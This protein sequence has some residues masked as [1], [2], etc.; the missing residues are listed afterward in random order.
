MI[1]GVV[2]D[3]AAG[4]GIAG[5][6][7]L[8]DGTTF[9]TVTDARGEFRVGAAPTGAAATVSHAASAAKSTTHRRT[10]GRPGCRKAR[11]CIL[12]PKVNLS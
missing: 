11:F 3:S 12:T 10:A 9:R 2:I 1:S 4:M 7:V 5:A 6:E 8:V